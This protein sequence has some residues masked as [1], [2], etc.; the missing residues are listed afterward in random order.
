MKKV[1]VLA[2]DFPPLI[3]IGAQRPYS[4]YKY[5]PEFDFEVTVVTRHW[6]G[7]VNSPSDY[8]KPTQNRTLTTVEDKSKVIRVP[9]E[10]NM[11]DSMLLKYGAARFTFIRKVLSLVLSFLEHL[12]FCFDAKS[13]IYEEAL[14][15]LSL[16]QY[17]LIVATG[18]PF[19]LFKYGHLLSK[20]IK[21]PWIADYRDGWTHNQGKYQLSLIQKLQLA[22]FRLCETKYLSNVLCVTTASPDYAKN[23]NKIISEKPIE[24]IYNGFDDSIFQ[25]VPKVAPHKDIFYVTYA[26]TIYAHQNLEM[27]LDGVSRFI[28]DSEVSTLDFKVRFYGIEGQQSAIK[29]VETYSHLK[30]Y[31]SYYPRIAYSDIV[32]LLRESRMLLLLSSPGVDWLNAKIFDYLATERPILLVQNDNGILQK[33]ITENN[34]GYVTN[35]AEDV[36]LALFREFKKFKLREAPDFSP[37]MNYKMFSRKAQAKRFAEL[38]TSKL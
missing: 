16:N 29:R 10:P 17:D 25:S 13:K 6:E 23:L 30:P 14:K 35:S 36:A 26:G 27:F 2:Y 20:K 4:W 24:V 18:E 3:S 15:E 19:V 38:I 33:L 34:S 21:I 9:Y 37:K 11:R 1:L 28:D 31:I 32:W 12:S 7:S 8:A 5:L 22:F